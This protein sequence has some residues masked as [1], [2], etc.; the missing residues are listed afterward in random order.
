MVGWG[1]S[2]LISSGKFYKVWKA[3]G[4]IRAMERG[5]AGRHKNI[6]DNCGARDVV[7]LVGTDV[8]GNR[9]YE[10]YFADDSNNS[11]LTSRWVE[12][13]DR[14]DR[15]PTGRKI[16]PEWHGWLHRCYDDAPTPDNTAFHNP[17]Y[18]KRHLANPS[19]EPG[20][21]RP[22][23]YAS[24]PYKKEFQEYVRSRIYTAWEPQERS[25]KKYD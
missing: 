18:K 22:L 15:F 14:N 10:D 16:P 2:A 4:F 23:G 7:P 1:I 12:F 5:R 19:G 11:S 25:I 21:I 24:H 17:P 13:V 20:A 8:H 3:E 6:L 9:Y